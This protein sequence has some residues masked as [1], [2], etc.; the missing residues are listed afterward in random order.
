MNL[1]TTH[2]SYSNCEVCQQISKAQ[3]PSGRYASEA[4]VF[5]FW[6]RAHWTLSQLF[7][8]FC[9]SVMDKCISAL[10]SWEHQYRLD[11]ILE[12]MLPADWS[13]VSTQEMQLN[14]VDS[15]ANHH[16]MC[17]C[18]ATVPDIN[19]SLF[20]CNYSSWPRLRSLV[21]LLSPDGSSVFGLATPVLHSCGS[22]EH[23]AWDL[24]P[25][26]AGHME[27]IVEAYLWWVI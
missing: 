2:S 26:P 16:I 1:R 5:L 21:Q 15:E 13:N 17:F 12:E 11:S 23:H 7:V 8:V 10:L 25:F 3:E 27:Y 4:L 14:A 6:L 24:H 9:F 19:T 20:L 18:H 22:R